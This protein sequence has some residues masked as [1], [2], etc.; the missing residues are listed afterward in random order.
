LRETEREIDCFGSALPENKDRPSHSLVITHAVE[1][2]F[3]WVYFYDSREFSETGEFLHALA[4]NAP[5]IVSRIDGRLYATGTAHPTE[6]Y[7]VEF[8]LRRSSPVM[9]AGGMLLNSNVRLKR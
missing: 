4:G 8:S 2:D 1:Q 3:G 9:T 5:F 6:H 7:L